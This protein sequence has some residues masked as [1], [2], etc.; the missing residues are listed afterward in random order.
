L[1]GVFVNEYITRTV[2]NNL[3][4]AGLTVLFNTKVPPGDGGTALGQ[5]C[6]AL[7]SVI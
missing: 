1:G 4:E 2:A 6:S 3:R 5:V 7:D